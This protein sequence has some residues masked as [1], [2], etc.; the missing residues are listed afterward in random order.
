[1]TTRQAKGREFDVIVIVPLDARRWP[2]DA[3]HRCLLTFTGDRPGPH[4]PR[5]TTTCTRRSGRLLT[6][7]DNSPRLGHPLAVLV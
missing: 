2:D 6:N 5:V 3:G 1:M 7:R 4:W